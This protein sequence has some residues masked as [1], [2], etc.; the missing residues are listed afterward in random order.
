[1]FPISG[2]FNRKSTTIAVVK[3]TTNAAQT[4]LTA[5]PHD[6]K[7]TALQ[8][9]ARTST[10]VRTISKFSDPEICIAVFFWIRFVSGKGKRM[11]PKDDAR[12]VKTLE[13]AAGPRLTYGEATDKERV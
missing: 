12:L 13:S 3:P 10:R 5:T 2:R 7:A 6:R 1:M 11:P 9:L 4:R 8:I